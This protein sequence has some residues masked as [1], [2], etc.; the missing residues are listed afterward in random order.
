[1]WYYAALFV[2]FV[3]EGTSFPLVHIPSIV[4]FLVSAYLV[5]AGNV[6]LAAVIL[7][8]TAGST[9][10][11]F[12]TYWL[13]GRMAPRST[14]PAPATA[15]GATSVGEHHVNFWTKPDRLARVR[16]FALRYGALLA[17]ASRW[18]G[19]LRPAALLGTGMAHV[20]PWKVLPALFVGSL[21]YCTAYQLGAQALQAVSIRL[22][23]EVET[24][25][26]LFYVVLLALVWAGGIYV[27]RKVRL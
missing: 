13:A 2:A 25:W 18:L 24:E 22:L 16:S 6:S 20:K 10:G 21:T 12:I 15:A 14:E 8:A 17:L 19:V 26:V 1:M 23:R 3:A 7:V 4:M 9:V 11:G 27:I 5:A